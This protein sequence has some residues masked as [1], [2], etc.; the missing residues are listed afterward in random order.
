MFD[1]VHSGH[2][3]L[4]ML[5]KEKAK[6]LGTQPVIITFS[7]H[8]QTIL[9]KINGK[10]PI[11]LLQ[12]NEE[13]FH[14]LASIGF[15]TIITIPFTIEFSHL[16]AI[17]FLNLL[18]QKYNPQYLLLG[19]DNHFGSALADE[20]NIDAKKALSDKGLVFERTDC[21]VTCNGI[22]VSS[23]QIRKALAC[24]NL[25][26]ANAMLSTPYSFEGIVTQGNHLG[27]TIDYATANLKTTQE[28][29]LPKY[30]VYETRVTLNQKQYKGITNIGLHPT[31][32]GTQPV[33]ETHILGFKENIY[34]Q[35]IKVELLRF[36]REEIK[37]SSLAEL[38][39][40][41]KKD[42]SQIEL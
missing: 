2:R 26:Q 36:L 10:T 42:I 17:D 11:G 37:F 15:D 34:N 29:L 25:S 41:I 9:S 16:S 6:S 30:G 7:N 4:L 39:E 40:Q 13:R 28:K 23:T 38:K 8:P 20:K 5:L 3:K 12:T 31:V 1:G 24:G 22:E 32:P 21:C 33:I 18:S 27:S 14:T 19:Y 35:Q